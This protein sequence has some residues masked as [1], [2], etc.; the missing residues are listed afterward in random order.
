MVLGVIGI[1]ADGP[2]DL[3]KV[4]PWVALYVVVDASTRVE[5]KELLLTRNEGGEKRQKRP[6][7]ELGPGPGPVQ[8][9]L[10]FSTAA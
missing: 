9:G 7:V 8:A 4:E 5:L 10:C 6:G 1:E 3:P 2:G